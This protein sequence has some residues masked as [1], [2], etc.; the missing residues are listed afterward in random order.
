MAHFFNF[1]H[2][3][4][5]PAFSSCS[6]EESSISGPMSFRTYGYHKTD[7]ELKFFRFHHSKRMLFHRDNTDILSPVLGIR[8]IKSQTFHRFIRLLPLTLNFCIA[9]F[10]VIPGRIFFRCRLYLLFQKLI[11]PRSSRICQ[12]FRQQLSKERAW[13]LFH[14][15]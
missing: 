14:K 9:L 11:N 10:S 15:A 13:K 7:A 3:L 1:L 4:S 5:N 8:S 6:P 2:T 12:L